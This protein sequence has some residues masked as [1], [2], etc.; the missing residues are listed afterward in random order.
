MH[1]KSDTDANRSPEPPLTHPAATPDAEYEK[2]LPLL[3][4][5]Y[6]PYANLPPP[7]PPYEPYKGI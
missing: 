2:Q 6:R 3:E 7:G 1:T 5:P 4:P